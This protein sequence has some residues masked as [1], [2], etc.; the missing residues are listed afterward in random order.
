MRGAARF[1]G[2][3]RESHPGLSRFR[4]IFLFHCL[5]RGRPAAILS[6]DLLGRMVTLLNMHRLGRQ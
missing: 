6:T 5:R 3:L 4:N 2:D 1:S